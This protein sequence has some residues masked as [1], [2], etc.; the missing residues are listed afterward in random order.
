MNKIKIESDDFLWFFYGKF[1]TL[2][3]KEVIDPKNLCRYFWL[4]ICGLALWVD[5]EMRLKWFWLTGAVSFGVFLILFLTIPQNIFIAKI[6]EIPAI[7]IF[8]ISIVAAVIISID[9]LFENL[10]KK[11]A[12]NNWFYPVSIVFIIGAIT[13]KAIRDNQF[14]QE[15]VRVFWEI[16]RT[17]PYFLAGILILAGLIFL[18]IYSLRRTSQKLSRALE[19]TGEFITAKKSRICPLVSPPENFKPPI[20]N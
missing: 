15:L 6:L 19:T 14:R 2:R 7:I 10:K 12:L 16:S 17:L 20:E 4:A 3:G 8:Q 11:A 1:F 9:R 13:V 18:L 5:K